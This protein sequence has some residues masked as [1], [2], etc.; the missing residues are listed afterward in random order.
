VFVIGGAASVPRVASFG[1]LS[2]P[3]SPPPPFSSS[4]PPTPPP[5]SLAQSLNN[6]I[7]L[8]SVGRSVDDVMNQRIERAIEQ[9]RAWVEP[10]PERLKRASAPRGPSP[11]NAADIDW[12]LVRGKVRCC[13]DQLQCFAAAFT[14]PV[15]P[16]EVDLQCVVQ[17]LLVQCISEAVS[18]LYAHL[19]TAH[20]QSLLESLQG[21][22]RFAYE[23]NNKADI[24]KA[25][26]QNGTPA[27][28]AKLP[29]LIPAQASFGCS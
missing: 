13:A 18:S 9:G 20:M 22:Y 6:D 25:V 29:S 15:L 4:P 21:V 14:V 17:L 24:R 11:L 2:A 12:R 23:A 19:S 28:A 3:P 26:T 5:A 1:E 8:D 7:D 16:S 10:L 27:P